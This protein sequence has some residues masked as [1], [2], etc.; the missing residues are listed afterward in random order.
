[1]STQITWYGHATLGVETEGYH[2]LID[3]FFSGNKAAPVSAEQV[4]ADA[5]LI[6]HGHGDHVGDAIAIAQRTKA[7]VIS[8][9]EICNWLKKNG[10]ANLHGQHIGGG[11]A[12]PFGY[13]KLTPALHGCSLPDGSYGGLAGGFHIITRDGKKLYFAGDTGLFGDMKLIGEGGLDLGLAIITPWDRMTRCW[14]CGCCA[15]KWWCRFT[16]TPL[17]SSARTRPP[18]Q[19]E[20]G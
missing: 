1:M 18:G 3:P 2:L 11:Y 20:F 13:V 9:F 16:T 14:P 5:I 7:V 10:V 15:Q 19:K 4:K 6:T 8:N 12:H 17:R